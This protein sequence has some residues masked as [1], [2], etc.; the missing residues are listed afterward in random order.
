[1]TSDRYLISC[2]AKHT[3]YNIAEAL[4]EQGMR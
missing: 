2:G 4:F 3:L 1:M